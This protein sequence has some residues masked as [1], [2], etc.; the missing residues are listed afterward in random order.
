MG[1]GQEAARGRLETARV[2]GEDAKGQKARLDI[3]EYI[4]KRKRQHAGE[5]NYTPAAVPLQ[6]SRATRGKRTKNGR[7]N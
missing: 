1:I 3:D 2:A 4:R 6:I 5:G 7:V